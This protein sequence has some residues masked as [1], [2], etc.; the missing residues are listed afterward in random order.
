MGITTLSGFPELLPE[1]QLVQD[2][3]VNTIRN[4]YQSYGYT[5]IETPVVER[6][7]VLLAKGGEDKEIYGVQRYAPDEKQPAPDMGLHYDL[8]IPLAR[9]VSQH[10][11]ELSFPFKRSQ[12]QKC[13]RGERPQ[14]GRFREFIQADVDVI[15]A[16]QAPLHYDAEVL[17][18]G[19]R[20]LHAIVPDGFDITVNNRK[21]VDGICDSFQLNPQQR[22]VFTSTIDKLHKIGEEKCR[23]FLEEAAI[24]SACIDLMFRAHM[25]KL[26]LI[27]ATALF[28]DLR[29]NSS[30]D[31]GLSELTTVT[32]HIPADLMQYLKFDPCT[33]RGLN[34]YTGT[35]FEGALHSR[36]DLSVCAG[37]R[38]DN[39]SELV[40][41]QRLP[42]VGMSIGVSRLVALLKQG[43]QLST[44]PATTSKLLIAAFSEQQRHRCHAVANSLRQRSLSC[45][46]HFN[47][48][49]KP[50]KQIQYAIRKGI[51]FILFV[52]DDGALELKNLQT[53]EQQPTT[54]EEL[55]GHVV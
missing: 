2:K 5:P 8:T 39:L 32:D 22:A 20:A 13:W 12:I 14:E 28:D 45:E 24:P 41:K 55:P 53:Q 46:E 36:P 3:L 43:N 49:S 38:Y 48:E 44:G 30:L 23:T 6:M 52:G 54:L 16:D 50:G 25:E 51:Q 47:F 33:M 7:E 17:E 19:T 11:N 34:Y 42:G 18:V 27:Q 1:E 35:I 40:G 21:L 26:T 9:Y 10:R 4:I 31:L 29:G 37:G 15:C